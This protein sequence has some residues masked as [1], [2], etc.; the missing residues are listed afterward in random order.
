MSK[1]VSQNYFSQEWT[2]ERRCQEVY[3]LEDK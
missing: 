2:V 3:Q 1:W